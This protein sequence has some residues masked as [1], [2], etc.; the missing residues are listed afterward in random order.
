MMEQELNYGKAID[1]SRTI[2]PPVG[3]ILKVTEWMST[4]VVIYYC[5]LRFYNSMVLTLPIFDLIPNQKTMVEPLAWVGITV[6]AIRL[7]FEC[8]ET[9]TAKGMLP[10]VGKGFLVVICCIPFFRVAN[11]FGYISFKCIAYAGLCLYGVSAERF[12]KIFALSI[13]TALAS[14]ILCAL[15]GGIENVCYWEDAWAVSDNLRSSYGIGYPTDFASYL[16]FLFLFFWS[17]WERKRYIWR[18][19]LFFCLALAFA[20]IAHD[21]ARSNTCTFCM[22][23]CCILVLYEELEHTFFPRYQITRRLMKLSAGFAMCAFPMLGIFFNTLVWAYGNRSGFALQINAWGHNRLAFSWKAIQQYGLHAFG[24]STPQRG[25]GGS[26]FFPENYEFLDSSYALMLIRYGWVLTVLIAFLWVWMTVRA[27][28]NGRRCLAYS[29]AVIAIHSFSEHHFPELNYN[30]LLAMP[31]CVFSPPISADDTE[32]RDD[33]NR[34]L[35]WLP[36]VIGFVIAGMIAVLFPGILARLRTF[37]T[38]NA[39]TDGETYSALAFLY[40]VI[41][42]LLIGALWYL[43]TRTSKAV[44]RKEECR[45]TIIALLLTVVL[46]TC[47]VCAAEYRIRCGMEECESQ[48]EADSVAVELVL[49]AAQ[50]PVYADGLEAIYRKRFAG[51]SDHVFTP[52]E[53]ARSRRGSIVIDRIDEINKLIES[54]AFYT[55]LSAFVGIYTYDE[56]VVQAL[57]NR[58][59]RPINIYYSKQKLNL[60]SAARHS[61]LRMTE[62]GALILEGEEKPLTEHSGVSLARGSHLVRFSISVDPSILEENQQICTLG[63]MVNASN[64]PIVEEMILSDAF[65]RDGHLTYEITVNHANSRTVEFFVIPAGTN[66]VYVEEISWRRLPNS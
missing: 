19:V 48:L 44:I 35:Q 55:E 65:D 16:L 31:L 63:M 58:G 42:V 26:E 41:C 62:D 38:L 17:A 36:Y 32:S 46:L 66:V 10:I 56:A 28:K 59:Y 14:T 53:L 57:E 33:H 21:Y 7:V 54:G 43:V 22:I 4:L 51:F 27:L 47:T 40:C 3:I 24:A 8:T 30:I 15:S 23:L 2:S 49:N 64:T 1:I 39:W 6:F 13:G 9:E 11:T 52:A 5:L 18:T 25:A 50:E 12:L 60:V 45:K 61:G 34:T 29:M 37:F 20:Y